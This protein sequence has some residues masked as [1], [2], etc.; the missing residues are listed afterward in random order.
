MAKSITE[1]NLRI[2]QKAPQTK[3]NNQIWYHELKV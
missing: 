3:Q 2:M 1:I